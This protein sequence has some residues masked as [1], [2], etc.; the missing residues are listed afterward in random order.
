MDEYLLVVISI[1]RELGS[2]YHPM[3]TS[4]VL[5][6]HSMIT[7]L[8]PPFRL[9]PS[10]LFSAW[11]P[12]TCCPH[13]VEIAASHTIALQTYDRKT[14]SQR[15]QTYRQR[16]QILIVP[17]IAP[18]MGW[19]SRAEW[20][21]STLL[22]DEKKGYSSDVGETASKSCA[23]LITLKSDIH[24]SLKYFH[25]VPK[26]TVWVWPERSCLAGT[27]LRQW[28]SV[29]LVSCCRSRRIWAY[30]LFSSAGSGRWSCHAVL[31][32]S[33]PRPKDCVQNKSR[34]K[35]IWTNRP[36]VPFDIFRFSF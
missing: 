6:W 33:T 32:C 8:S 26:P 1:L 27:E 23:M 10:V 22:I 31:E 28:R 30:N 11:S 17:A 25:V 7:Y 24:P 34:N 13:L 12:N 19:R 4:R 21:Q 15:A 5:Y 2:R 14:Y 29:Q 35:K 36:V 18:D 16:R 20:M 3:E 9:R